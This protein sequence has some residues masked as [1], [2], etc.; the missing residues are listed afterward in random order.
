MYEEADNLNG[1]GVSSYAIHN[2][3]ATFL[4]AMLLLTHSDWTWV[5]LIYHIA[6]GI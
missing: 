4:E 1:S 3:N 5:L 6:C 2:G